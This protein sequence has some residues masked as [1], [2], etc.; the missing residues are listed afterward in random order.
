MKKTYIAFSVFVVAV[1]ILLIIFLATG[2]WKVFFY[3]K[4]EELVEARIITPQT[5]SSHFDTSLAGQV[6]WD[7]R[8]N[9]KISME[10]GETIVAIL[11]RERGEGLPEEQFIAYINSGAE[12]RVYIAYVS[13]DERYRRYRR[14]WDAP[15]AA[16]RP[17]TVSI[18]SQDLI[19]D[20]NNCIIVTGMN[21]RNEHTMTIFRRRYF[22]RDDQ[23]FDIIAELQI[24]GS[25]IIQETGRSLA[26]QQGIA[27]GQ[28][29]NIAA[30]GHDS[31][32]ANILDQIETI[33]SFDQA[34]QLYEQSS[35][36][37]IPGS[38]IEQRRL[39]ELL[40]G[41]PGVFE[42]FINDLWF[43]VS[44]QGTIDPNQYLYF[45]PSGR[46]IIFYGDEAQQVFRWHNSTPTRSGLYIRSQNISI[47]TLFR[48][49][50]IE[51]ES[52]DS[53]RL[54]VIEDVR[55]RITANTTWDGTYRRAGTVVQI[56]TEA[57]IR[58]AVNALYD[59]AWGRVQFNLNGEYAISSG[60][61][62]TTGRYV[63]FRVNGN[64]L[65][66]LRPDERTETGN[67]RMIYKVETLGT[68]AL[69]LSHVRLGTMGIQDLL[70]TPIILTPVN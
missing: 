34:S 51:L 29:F 61:S 16:T 43:Y 32:S 58:P 67:N 57:P 21:N 6:R 11:N 52:L 37:R 12:R 10:D 49:I 45:D 30:Y 41:V 1:S 65:L 63:F 4:T 47:G 38:Q 8:L 53:I 68:A 59:S 44:P 55:L 70:E 42:N 40:S 18:F 23:A 17:E 60:N 54:R 35:V 13:F 25:I 64:E 27:R 26:Y 19:G 36:S 3:P 28:S 39:R 50:D 46:E 9:A 56:E 5:A 33:Y 7:E 14:M 31:S 62:I 2:L 24:D 22:Q 20:R 66:E 15:T 69:S 48:F